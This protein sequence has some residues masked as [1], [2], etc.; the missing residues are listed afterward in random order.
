MS[1]I[2][3]FKHGLLVDWNGSDDV[4]NLLITETITVGEMKKNYPDLYEKYKEQH[5]D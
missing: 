1:K 5:E 4:S 3:T 2:Q